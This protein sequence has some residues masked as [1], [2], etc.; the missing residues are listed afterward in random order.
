MVEYLAIQ[1]EQLPQTADEQMLR[2]L[3][4]AVE[5]ADAKFNERATVFE[6]V[7]RTGGA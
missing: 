4:D 5:G 2:R 7:T 1:V 3:L 6:D